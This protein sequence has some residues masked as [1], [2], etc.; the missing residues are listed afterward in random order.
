VKRGIY[1]QIT[2]SYIADRKTRKKALKLIKDGLAHIVASDGHNLDKRPPVMKMAYEIVYKA[3]GSRSA[4][5]LFIENPKAMIMD[6]VLG[7]YNIG[8]K[9]KLQLF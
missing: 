2:S 6:S 9:K 5:L 8:K 1:C 3:F 4:D 7:D